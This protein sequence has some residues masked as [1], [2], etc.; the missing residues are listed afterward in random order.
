MLGA[1]SGLRLASGIPGGRATG[2]PVAKGKQ[3]KDGTPHCFCGREKEP[4]PTHQKR[5]ARFA[6]QFLST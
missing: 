4:R 5:L 6:S 2:S 3:V 1:A